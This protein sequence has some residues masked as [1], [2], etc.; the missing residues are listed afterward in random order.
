MD[1]YI[2]LSLSICDVS[3]LTCD[4]D[5]KSFNRFLDY[6]RR[7]HVSQ[8]YKRVDSIKVLYRFNLILILISMLLQIISNF[9]IMDVTVVII[10]AISFLLLALSVSLTPRYLNDLTCF[11]PYMFTD[12]LLL[13]PLFGSGSLTKILLYS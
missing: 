7:V 6:S 9:T 12:R 11:F 5:L 2:C 1:I 10:I 13:L 4:L 8:P 3:I